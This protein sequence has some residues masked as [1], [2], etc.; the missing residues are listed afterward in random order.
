[1]FLFG[2]RSNKSEPQFKLKSISYKINS[3]P[4]DKSKSKSKKNMSSMS[5]GE[6]A[7]LVSVF[8]DVMP[9]SKPKPIPRE[10]PNSNLKENLDTFIATIEK[11][12]KVNLELFKKSVEIAEKLRQYVVTQLNHLSK[13]RK[14]YL[15][16][17]IGCPILRKKKDEILIFFDK[18]LLH[19]INVISSYTIHSLE[20]S[21]ET[22]NDILNIIKLS[23]IYIQQIETYSSKF[24]EY[25]T[26]NKFG[27]QH[28]DLDKDRFDINYVKSQDLVIHPPINIDSELNQRINDCSKIIKQISDL[29]D[30]RG[31]ITF[32]CPILR[33]RK[34][35]TILFFEKMLKLLLQANQLVKEKKGQNISNDSDKMLLKNIENVCKI[36]SHHIKI[37][38][39][40]VKHNF[41]NNL[42]QNKFDLGFHVVKYPIS[43]GKTQNK[44][45]IQRF[46]K[47]VRQR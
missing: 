41:D 12:K 17:T 1:M 20:I 42:K 39:E 10:E 31:K 3:I 8:T 45:N 33:Q 9:P 4:T 16:T 38:Q 36:Y 13:C 22:Q 7:E 28:I 5:S 40:G 14:S 26:D 35:K 47:T 18:T 37:Y 2:K 24:H 23:R 32:G 29:L 34:N 46:R 21:K 6:A 27:L 11:N 19:Q 44:R 15:G 25:L 30:C 43:G